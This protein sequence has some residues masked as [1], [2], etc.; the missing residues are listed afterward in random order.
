MSDATV[1]RRYAQALYQEADAAGK[2]DRIDEDMQSRILHARRL[3]ARDLPS[4]LEGAVA[5][6]DP[7]KLNPASSIQ[8]NLLF[9]KI[10]YR[11]PQAENQVR[12]IVS[13]TLRELDLIEAVIDIGLDFSVGVGGGRLSSVQRQKLAIARALVKKPDLLIL[14]NPFGTF[15]EALRLSLIDQILRAQEGRGVAAVVDRSAATDRFDRIF[16][17][18]EGRIVPADDLPSTTPKNGRTEGSGIPCR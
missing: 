1:A 13:E 10:A 4:D 2:V 15:D 6:F 17:A 12:A 11:R 16:I 18:Q 3:F 9:G 7:E 8:D 5:F 14:N